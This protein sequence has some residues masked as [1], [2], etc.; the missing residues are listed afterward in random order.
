[1]R[2][3]SPS[4]AF[5]LPAAGMSHGSAGIDKSVYCP[6]RCCSEPK[7][8]SNKSNS[9][10]VQVHISKVWIESW[11]THTVKAKRKYE[12]FSGQGEFTHEDASGDIVN[13]QC[14]RFVHREM[15]S[16][17][18]QQRDRSFMRKKTTFVGRLVTGFTWITQ[19]MTGDVWHIGA[20]TC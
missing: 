17:S 20:K 1:M 8:S 13:I 18:S 14:E 16:K 6:R 2:K 19:V 4:V 12:R 11:Y 3:A 10:D 15:W 7:A 9:R 5:D